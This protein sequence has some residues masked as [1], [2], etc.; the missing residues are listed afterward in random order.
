MSDGEMLEY[1]GMDAAKWAAEFCKIA[2]N[3]G[4]NLDEEWMIGWF[5]SAIMAGYDRGRGVS[6]TKLPDGSAFIVD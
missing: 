3:H 1:M 5:A 2:R 4:H 6:F